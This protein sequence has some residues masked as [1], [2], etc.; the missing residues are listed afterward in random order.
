MLTTLCLALT[1]SVPLLAQVGRLETRE[2]DLP[3]NTGAPIVR[4]DFERCEPREAVLRDERRDDTWLLRTADWPTPLLNAVGSP[5]DLIYDPQLTGL[6]DIYLGSRATHFP[7]TL[8]L[9]LASEDEFTIITSPRGTERL[10][11]DWEFCFRR[12]VKLDGERLVLRALG[13]AVYVDYLRFVPAPSTR[14]G[15]ARVATDHVVICRETGKHFAFP[16][17]VRLTDGS[18]AAVFR[19]GT[20]HIDP[21]GHVALCRSNDGGRT[22]SAREAIYD[23]PAVDERDPGLLQHSGGTL[24]ASMHSGSPITLRSTDGGR[25]WDK[26]AVAPV[27]SPHGPGELP[28]GRLFWCGIVT[29]Q[30]TNHVQIAISED[31]GRTWQVPIT[32]A[33]SLPYHQPW[34]RPFWDEP[35]AVPLGTD[36]WLCQYRV[37]VDGYLYQNGSDD[38]GETFSPPER[39]PLWGCPPFVLRLQD[40]RL[41]AVYGYRRAPWGV[42]A[43]LSADEGVTWNLDDEIVVRDDGG[44]GDLGYPVALELEPGLVFAVYY[45]NQGGEECTI[46]GTWLRL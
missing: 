41:L 43:C 1:L 27:F 8:G 33:L 28:D 37:D 31:L 35:V 19:A 12:E 2:V 11:Y 23:D 10:H 29:R 13:D 44:H 36:R 3:A 38:G 40:G 7:V 21:S 15:L 46:E 20:A 32:T 45:H 14:R 25:M 22:W 18:L 5:P 9:K 34:V 24:I 26:P 42:R 4:E 17:V 30:D 6:Y 39:L 16:G